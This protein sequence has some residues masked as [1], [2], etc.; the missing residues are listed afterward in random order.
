MTRWSKRPA[1]VLLV[2]VLILGLTACGEKKEIHKINWGTAPAY[3][4]EDVAL[5][6]QTGDL[7]GCCSDGEYMY[8]L[9]DEKTE[10]GEVRSVLSRVYLAD[11]TA[12]VL[13]DFQA[14]VVPDGGIKN[15]L[16]PV[17]APDGT[18]WLYEMWSIS[19]Y[20]LPENFD[21]EKEAKGQYFTGQEDFHHLRQLDPATG[22]QKELIDLSDAVRALDVSAIFDVAGLVVDGEGN[23]CFAGA[24]GVAVLDKNG[25]CLFTL[26][27]DLPYGA[28]GNTSGSS[29]ALLPDGTPAVLTVLPGGK[30]AVRTLDIAAKGW[31]AERYELPI[32][33]DLIYGGT[34]GF[35]FY[36]TNGG[37]L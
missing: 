36:Y 26:E 11:G 13:H 35:L 3:L 7:I 33:V 25:S 32:G 2:M 20:D 24:G 16:G 10:D 31:G 9:A 18:M 23:I 14:T 28:A 4:A 29:L 19:Y 5:P 8:V 12:E 6:V 15:T 30:R 1:A 21:P 27:A 17:L 34:N 22:R 37:A